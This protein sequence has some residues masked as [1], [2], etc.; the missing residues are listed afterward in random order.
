MS[1]LTCRPRANARHKRPMSAL[2]PFGRLAGKASFVSTMDPAE[3]CRDAGLNC[4]HGNL[5]PYLHA[6]RDAPGARTRS[7]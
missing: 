4:G 3:L 5:L 2:S 7:E 1:T 6:A